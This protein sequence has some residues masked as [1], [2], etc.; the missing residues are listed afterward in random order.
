MRTDGRIRSKLAFLGT[1]P[2]RIKDSCSSR[3]NFTLEEFSEAEAAVY[4]FPATMI[5]YKNSHMSK[6]SSFVTTDAMV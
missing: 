5:Y 6:A 2:R 1:V 3:G 4:F